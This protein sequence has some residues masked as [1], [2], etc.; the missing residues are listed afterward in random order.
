MPI[1]RRTFTPTPSPSHHPA[2]S[3]QCIHI[4]HHPTTNPQR[5]WCEFMKHKII[6][7]EW[8]IFISAACYVIMGCSQ[9][10][11]P[12]SSNNLAGTWIMEGTNVV[13]HFT[14]TETM[15]ATNGSYFATVEVHYSGTD[16][17]S[18]SSMSGTVQIRHGV[19][20]D[21]ITNHSNTNVVLPWTTSGK[22]IRLSDR[23][24][25]VR[26]E[27][28]TQGEFSTNLVIFRREGTSSAR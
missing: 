25:A 13:G 8:L 21:T 12:N 28:T 26:W 11:H 17:I 9:Q 5:P 1:Y 4:R 22:I 14:R 10:G 2:R 18:T 24:L 6:F 16:Q 20:F 15:V 23:E 7:N 3:S 27:K 19:L